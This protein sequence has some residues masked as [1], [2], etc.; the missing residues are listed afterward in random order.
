MASQLLP[1][2]GCLA[3]FPR[4][5]LAPGLCGPGLGTQRVAPPALH[6]CPAGQHPLGVR[7]G[8]CCPA[9]PDR[10]E[11]LMLPHLAR[12]SA[13]KDRPGANG[14]LEGVTCLGTGHVRDSPSLPGSLAFALSSRPTLGALA[15][16]MREWPLQP[17]EG[18]QAECPPR[19]RLPP[20]HQ[21]PSGQQG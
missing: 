7:L 21:P 12:G 1:W 3:G 19:L 20:G 16:I 14:G 4:W 13:L 11:Q 17:W 15:L 18:G 2:P 6:L 9:G 8:H 5:Q 10:R